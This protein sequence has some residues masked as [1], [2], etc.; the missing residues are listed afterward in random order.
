MTPKE[1][2]FPHVLQSWKEIAAYLGC[3]ERTCQRWEK[4]YELPIR[5]LGDGP[6]SRIYAR[7]Q[8][9]DAWLQTRLG[10][11][12]FGDDLNIPSRLFGDSKLSAEE[13]K[14]TRTS[15]DTDK[16]GKSRIRIPAV[17][18]ALIIA[19]VAFLFLGFP[20][21]RDPADYRVKG[22]ALVIL[23]ATGR[24]LWRHEADTA[25][26]LRPDLLGPDSLTRIINLDETRSLPHFLI[27]DITGDGRSEVLF[28][29]Q[30][31][32]GRSAGGLFVFDARGRLLWTYDPGRAI[33]FG[34]QI[35]SEDF[36]GAIA[37]FDL[38]DDGRHE[39]LVVA[40][41]LGYFPTVVSLLDAEG[42]LLGEYWNSGQIAD[43]NAVD[44]DGDGRKEILLA[45]VNNEY[46][47]GFLAVLDTTD[48]GGASPQQNPYYTS[49]ELG[50]GKEMFYIRFPQ[51]AIDKSYPQ[52]AIA[53]RLIVNPAAETLIIELLPSTIHYVLNFGMDRVLVRMTHGFERIYAD[54]LF[55]GRIT[56][57]FDRDRILSELTEGV[58]WWDGEDWSPQPTMTSYH[59]DK[60]AVKPAGAGWPEI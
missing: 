58:L 36:P 10:K 55:H 34:P 51:S 6:R 3:D 60:T 29:P 7:K 25:N 38:N 57:P 40:H 32:D 2:D 20:E 31:I 5:R 1:K 37:T 41:S 15:P 42:R 13:A 11:S 4:D 48:M 22:S 39:I 12:G 35:Y 27:Q 9:I 56:E 18:A 43:V 23:D 46:R 26:S 53:K 30:D 52:A 21:R 33:R 47:S 59:R 16:A 17:A 19:A 54:H 24:E 8:E 49:P 14:R 50:P 44:L 45:G 28:Y